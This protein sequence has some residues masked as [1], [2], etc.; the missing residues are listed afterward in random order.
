MTV[1]IK[2]FYHDVYGSDMPGIN[3]LPNSGFENWSKGV[4]T[5]I[6]SDLVSNGGFDSAATDW[7]GSQCTLASVGSGESGNCLEITRTGDTTQMAYQ[8]ITL[9]EGKT[10]RFTFWVKSG[11]SG[12]EPFLLDVTGG[13]TGTAGPWLTSSLSRLSSSTWTSYSFVYTAGSDANHWVRLR[14]ISSTAGTMLFDTVSVYEVTPAITAVTIDGPDGGWKN[15][16]GT[17]DLYRETTEVKD[18]TLYSLKMVKSNTGL[19]EMI[20]PVTNEFVTLAKG[21]TLAFGAWVKTT[22]AAFDIT[23]TDAI[24]GSSSGVHSGGGDWEWLETTF[25]PSTSATQFY[26][27]LRF[28]SG[29]AN[30]IAYVCQP[31]V[32]FGD[33]IGE[34]NYQSN[35]TDPYLFGASESLGKQHG[36]TY[37]WDEERGLIPKSFTQTNLLTNSGFENWSNGTIEEIG[38]DLVSNGDFTTDTTGWTGYQGTIASVSGGESGN[39]CQI[40]APGGSNPQFAY[41]R[42]NFIGNKIYK[43]SV[44]VKSGTSGNEAIHFD[45][46]GGATAADAPVIAILSNII[47]T[48]TWTKH[49]IYYQASGTYPQPW[50]RIGKSTSTAGTVLIDTVE[51]YEVTPACI[52]ADTLAPDGWYTHSTTTCY[53]ANFDSNNRESGEVKGGALYAVKAL[54]TGGQG[55]LATP[56]V[57]GDPAW[58]SK[59][60]GRNITFGAWVKSPSSSN[61]IAISSTVLGV[62]QT[63]HSGSNEWEWLELTISVP[64]TE[65]SIT[66]YYQLATQDQYNYICQPMLVLGDYIGEGNYGPKPSDIPLLGGTES[67][68]KQHGKTYAWDKD[69]GMV[70][71]DITLTNLLTNSG[72]ENWSYGSIEEMGSDLVSNGGFASAT[73]DWTAYQGTLV[74]VS[75]GESGNCLEITRTSGSIQLAYQEIALTQNKIY[76][77]SVWIKSGTSGNESASLALTGGAT[78]LDSPVLYSVTGAV[79]NSEWTKHSFYYKAGADVKHWIRVGKSSSTAGTMLFD[80]VEVHEVTP[81]IITATTNGPDGW[82]NNSANL[83]LY[84]ETVEVKDSALYSMKIVKSSTGAESLYHPIASIATSEDWARQ[85]RGRTITIGCWVKTDKTNFAVYTTDD[86]STSSSKLHTGSNEWEWLETTH[87]VSP[88]AAQFYGIVVNFAAG[89]INDTAYLCQPTLVISDSIGEG[90]YAPNPSDPPL[91]GGTES[92]GIKHGKTYTWDKDYGMQAKDITLTNLLPNSGMGVWSNSTVENVGSNLVSNGGFDSDTT[93]W[94]AGNGTIAS[95]AGG[96]SGNCLEFTQPGATPGYIYNTAFTTRIGKY[97]KLIAYAKSGTSGDEAATIRAYN[98]TLASIN[99]SVDITTSGTWTQYTIIFKAEDT[100]SQVYLYKNTA[101]IGTMLFDTIT[102]YEVT[103]GCVAAN[104]SGCDAWTKSVN[105]DIYRESTEVKEGASYSLKYVKGVTGDEAVSYFFDSNTRPSM[106]KQFA[107]RTLTFGC[108][109][110]ADSGIPAQIRI[111]SDVGTEVVSHSQSNEWEWLE[112]S[113]DVGINATYFSVSFYMT[114]GSVSDTAYFCQ[115]MLVFG[116][117]IGEGNY[118]P[119]PQEVISLETFITSELFDGAKTYSDVTYTEMEVQ[120]DALLKLPHNLKNI[121][122]Q[123][124]AT[125]SGSAGN[126]NLNFLL[127]PYS[128]GQGIGVTYGD[129]SV[130][131]WAINDVIA[132]VGEEATIQYNINASGSS[133][134]T[135]KLLYIGVQLV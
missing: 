134:S 56:M 60:K 70:A 8:E 25:T 131:Q 13:A 59:L 104:D 69:S 79:T 118:Q 66:I 4:L 50:L 48:P 6:G 74:S 5:N 32:V 80:T 18:G 110:K 35:P 20:W 62:T 130:S 38:N 64:E 102:C 122:A 29:S 123:M 128:S 27:T 92:L 107:G 54:A 105:S 129:L 23:L 46:T 82:R 78:G 42:L 89:S 84:R 55:Y 57:V 75:G 126:Y 103:P 65:T 14:K 71:K 3:L 47:S 96:Q 10:Y 22:N 100:L 2:D 77:I 33:Y 53:R 109:A 108:W 21:R 16:Q 67:L 112:V 72:F 88:N 15:N 26:W 127:R 30:D 52:G 81:A 34:G 37:T 106:V 49:T 113:L 43:I 87:T 111:T 124:W 51:V 97:Y 98:A 36:K 17:L 28:S 119:I 90:N 120:E 116:D 135:V 114:T 11:T 95:V 121:N 24:T 1:D 125:D 68:N 94:T 99:K 7:T 132:P 39:C 58:L 61:Y 40:T 12:D 76:K 117:Y 63:N 101:T 9:T 45:L 41:Q 115:P 83:K 44:W 19:E 86:I 85:F 133:T 93:G 31:M 91:V 73:T